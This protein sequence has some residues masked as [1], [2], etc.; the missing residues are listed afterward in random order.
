MDEFQS[1]LDVLREEI[2]ADMAAEDNV[3]TP[4]ET[5]VT[6]TDTLDEVEDV[7]EDTED[8]S[9]DGQSD[10]DEE[11]EQVDQPPKASESKPKKKRSRASE[12]I[13]QLVHAR[14]RL[15]ADNSALQNRLAEL[16]KAVLG[17]QT[18]EKSRK[19]FVDEKEYNAYKMNHDIQA[20]VTQGIE[21]YNQQQTQ[22]AETRELT[23]LYQKNLDDARQYIP[24]V[25]E[26]MG[27]FNPNIAISDKSKK[28]LLGSPA[29]VYT[30]YKIAND[31]Q[32]NEQ[33][34]YADP[35]QAEQVV[36]QIHD[37]IYAG[38]QN[39]KNG[40]KGAKSYG[41]GATKQP[42]PPKSTKSSTKTDIFDLDGE[43]FLEAYNKKFYNNA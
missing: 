15:E 39:Y 41:E 29:G 2:V 30:M 13:S 23:G 31:P 36:A 4:E 38:I 24:D 7:P 19:D 16:E 22:E 28:H 12:R 5:E 20:G 25:D 17:D 8:E 34:G 37:E 11:P 14:R 10:G 43:D 9:E 18:K 1:E 6:E 27:L 42:K 26:V 3:T 35:R 33:L 40:N 21:A 32:L